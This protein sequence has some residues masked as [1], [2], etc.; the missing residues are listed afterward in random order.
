M[1]TG[2]DFTVA[3]VSICATAAVVAFAQSAAKPLMASRVFNWSEMKVD[4][5][6]TGER[7]AL[8]DVPTA[9]LTRFESHITTLNPG[10]VPHTAHRHPEEE[11]MILKEGTLQVVQN[12]QT[13]RVEAG[14]IIFCASN[15]LHGMRNIGTNRATYYV[16]K[17]FPHDLNTAPAR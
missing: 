12:D 5:T 14:G 3:V 16:I 11:M 4:T 1:I 15:E 7:R 13:N 6:K 10:E 9:N 17:W 8:F 2:R